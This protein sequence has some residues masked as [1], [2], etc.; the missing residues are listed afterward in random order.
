SGASRPPIPC[1]SRP[2]GSSIWRRCG[3]T[4]DGGRAMTTELLFREDAYCRS[5]TARVTAVDERGVQLDR[6]I[7]YPQGGGQVGDTGLLVRASGERM[8]VADTRKGDALDSVLHILSPDSAAP[9]LGA[10]V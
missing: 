7:F 8:A 3:S 6:T 4:N 9:E 10:P 2:I 5:A 1:R